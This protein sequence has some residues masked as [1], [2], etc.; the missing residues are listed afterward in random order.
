QVPSVHSTMHIYAIDG[1]VHRVAPDATA[2]AH[3]D[4]TF[5]TNIVGVWPDAAD[6][7]A[8][9]AW[10]RGYFEALAPHSTEG[11]YVNFMSGDD[12]DRIRASY[13]D[14]YDRLV[15]VKRTYDPANLFRVNQNIEP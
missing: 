14:N 7:D 13:G 2:F 10:V 8:N 5:A 6:N 12:R 15:E 11:G 1:A 4:A 9:M 3:R